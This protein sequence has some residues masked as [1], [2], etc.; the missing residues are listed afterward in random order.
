MERGVVEIS[1]VASVR[2]DADGSN[3][4]VVDKVQDEDFES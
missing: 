3:E 2:I 4:V 1:R